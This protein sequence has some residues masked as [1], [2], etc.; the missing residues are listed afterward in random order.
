MAKKKSK[1]SLPIFALLAIVCAVVSICMMFVDSI[2]VVA[3]TS[4]GTSEDG[5]FYT[6]LQAVFG[7][8][9]EKT[10]IKVFEFSFMNLLPYLLL[11]GAIVLS[12]MLVLK[13]SN[14][15]LFSFVICG[16]L[17]AAG[18]LFFFEGAFTIIADTGINNI[19][20]GL[21]QIFGVESKVE[22]AVGAIVAAIS[23]LVGGALMAVSVFAKKSK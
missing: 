15:K 2:K 23:S 21:G 7:Y 5:V 14:N 8:T 16:L 19:A 6:G 12:V 20:S 17:I 11:V 3:E 1:K 4:K 10:K 9:D 18:V 22:L 13:K